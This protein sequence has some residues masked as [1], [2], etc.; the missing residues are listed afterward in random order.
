MP[1]KI[2]KNGHPK[3]KGRVQKNGI[4]RQ[5]LFDTKAEALAWEAEERKKDWNK[6]WGSDD[7]GSEK[8]GEWRGVTPRRA[9]NFSCRSPKMENAR[10]CTVL[11]RFARFLRVFW[12]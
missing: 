6:D 2:Q 12:Q 8:D 3:W 9:K 4:I 1:S 10:Q 11:H 7:I 5:K